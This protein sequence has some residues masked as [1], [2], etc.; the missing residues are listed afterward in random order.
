MNTK[1]HKSLHANANATSARFAFALSMQNVS[2]Y[3]LK[4]PLMRSRQGAVSVWLRG[5]SHCKIYK[6]QNPPPERFSNRRETT[7]DEKSWTASNELFFPQQPVDIHSRAHLHIMATENVSNSLLRL[8]SVEEQQDTCKRRR[9]TWWLFP[10][11]PGRNHTAE[12]RWSHLALK[13]LSLVTRV[14]LSASSL[15]CPP[16]RSPM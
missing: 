7:N 9:C 1:Q 14:H 15:L 3:F 12:R 6:T 10:K 13:D 2:L 11:H 4:L 16:I 8:C 5:S